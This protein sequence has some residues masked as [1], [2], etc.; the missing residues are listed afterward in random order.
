MSSVTRKRLRGQCL[1]QR[2]RTTAPV[3]RPG[4]A[5]PGWGPK[6]EAALGEGD[7][8]RQCSAPAEETMA[9]QLLRRD[10]EQTRGARLGCSRNGA[11]EWAVLWLG[12]R[13]GCE[14][15]GLSSAFISP[16][17]LS[18]FRLGMV[19]CTLCT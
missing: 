6:R 12:A 10:W 5:D 18:T 19:T 11:G 14:E 7:K 3:C 13:P 8:E 9:A 15:E 16:F 17:F 4:W 1:D 2:L